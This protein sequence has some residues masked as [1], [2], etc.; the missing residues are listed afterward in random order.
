[1]KKKISTYQN[2]GIVVPNPL[3]TRKVD[4]YIRAYGTPDTKTFAAVTTPKTM[5]SFDGQKAPGELVRTLDNDK[6]YDR[7]A[8]GVFH[9]LKNNV[10]MTDVNLDRNLPTGKTKDL[11]KGNFFGSRGFRGRYWR[12]GKDKSE[13]VEFRK[14]HRFYNPNRS[15]AVVYDASKGKRA[16]ADAGAFTTYND[17]DGWNTM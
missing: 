17:K 16:N 11:I 3:D 2:G 15:R 12:Y 9:G 6:H 14:D 4:K 8:S 10:T 5:V 7:S 1:M 13:K